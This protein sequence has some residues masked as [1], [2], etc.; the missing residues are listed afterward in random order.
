M[1]TERLSERIKELT[2]QGTQLPPNVQDEL[3]DR[4]AIE[5]DNAMWDAQL[6]DDAN[7]DSFREMI[8][9]ARHGPKVSWPTPEEAGVA[10]QLDAEDL[11]TLRE[12]EQE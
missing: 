4:L 6:A 11:A 10:D 5:L 12:T 7:L 8:E 2:T 9:E 3:A 1:L